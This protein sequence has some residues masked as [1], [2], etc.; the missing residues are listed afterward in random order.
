M[1]SETYQTRADADKA[2]AA[3]AKTENQRLRFE[4]S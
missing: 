3:N 1:N 2:E 4:K